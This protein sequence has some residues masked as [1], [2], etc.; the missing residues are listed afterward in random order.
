[1][2]LLLALLAIAQTAAQP[3]TMMFLASVVCN[4]WA[5]TM[6]TPSNLT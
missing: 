1:M 4:T 5:T 6:E 3:A 2:K